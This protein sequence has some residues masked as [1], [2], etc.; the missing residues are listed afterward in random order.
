MGV[1]AKRLD[2]FTETEIDDEIVVM[3]LDSGDFFSLSGTAAAAWRLIDGVR[4]RGQLIEELAEQYDT[5]DGEILSDV[6]DFLAQLEQLGLVS[7]S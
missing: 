7:M 3:T 5:R 1:I 2:R 6:E 4:D